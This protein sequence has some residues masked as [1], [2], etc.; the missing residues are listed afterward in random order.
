MK[1]AAA[2]LLALL[3]AF[4][5][6]ACGKGGEQTATET[7]FSGYCIKVTVPAGYTL[8]SVEESRALAG[9]AVLAKSEC[10]DVLLKIYCTQNG[11]AATVLAGAETRR[12]P[13]RHRKTWRPR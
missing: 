1:R 2:F 8:Y 6:A 11:V 3:I 4:S 13:Y 10:G 7:T 9:K 12:R 5:L